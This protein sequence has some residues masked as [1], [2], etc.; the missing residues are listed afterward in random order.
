MNRVCFK[1]QVN[2]YFHSPACNLMSFKLIYVLNS[3][4]ITSKYRDENPYEQRNHVSSESDD[5]Y[6][7][8][9]NEFDPYERYQTETVN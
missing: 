8:N 3:F 4:L 1:M 6:N 7:V 2:I 9:N 5:D